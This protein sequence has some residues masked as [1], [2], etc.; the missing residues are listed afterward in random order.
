MYKIFTSE[1]QTLTKNCK[2]VH[3]APLFEEEMELETALDTAA[4]LDWVMDL[5]GIQSHNQTMTSQLD[6]LIQEDDASVGTFTSVIAP[7]ITCAREGDSSL[8]PS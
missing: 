4:S 7:T 6:K 3:N 1:Y 8:A 2:W 5:S